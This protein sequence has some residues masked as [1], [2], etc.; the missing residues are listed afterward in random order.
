M[1]QIEIVNL[2]PKFLNFYDKAYDIEDMDMV[3]SLWEEHYNFAALPPVER[4][5]EMARNMLIEAWKQYESVLPRFR[6][7]QPDE[8][9]IRQSIQDVKEL[10]GCGEDLSVVITYYVGALEGNAFVAPSE[11]GRLALYL[12]VE[13]GE[14]DIILAHE[15]THIVHAKTA[16]LALEWERPIAE[17]VLAEGL[18]MRASMQIAPGHPLEA[19]AEF[20]PGWLQEAA[21]KEDDILNGIVP[22]LVDASSEAVARFTYDRGPAGLEREGYYAGWVLV[23]TLQEKGVSLKELAHVKK[24]DIPKF[25]RFHIERLT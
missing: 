9:V 22:H 6:D 16:G 21:S 20:T 24:K 12:S 18:A 15:M 4:R 14:T 19:Y 8:Q 1:D 13:T 10:L 7:F 17:V 5:R 3:F 23:G 25:V 2:V 11:E